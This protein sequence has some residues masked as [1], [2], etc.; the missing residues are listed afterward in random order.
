MTPERTV[1][2]VAEEPVTYAIATMPRP[3]AREGQRGNQAGHSLIVSAPK[4][5]P[6]YGWPGIRGLPRV[7]IIS[8]N[9]P[10]DGQAAP[11]GMQ[12][13]VMLACRT[14][15]DGSALRHAVQRHNSRLM[16]LVRAAA[17]QRGVRNC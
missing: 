6:P 8:P 5:S 16:R 9:H 15:F 4:V 3:V 2:A 13:D 11:T 14:G 10:R 17:R 7:P 1:D 12:V